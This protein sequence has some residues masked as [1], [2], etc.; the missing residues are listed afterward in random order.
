MV[1]AT[2]LPTFQEI[3]SEV[4]MAWQEYWH[5]EAERSFWVNWNT[6]VARIK[7]HGKFPSRL[8]QICTTF[9]NS[10]V[11]RSE[12][13]DTASA[14]VAMLFDLDIPHSSIQVAVGSG[15]RSDWAYDS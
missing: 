10:T 2:A 13:N 6:Y 4:V 3:R 8:G 9:V 12:M 7:A 1:A 11:Q 14:L 15:F 5:I